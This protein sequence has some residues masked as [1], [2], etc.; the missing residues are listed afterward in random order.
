MATTSPKCARFAV[1]RSY[2]LSAA[3]PQTATSRS[4]SS[5][6]IGRRTGSRRKSSSRL[7]RGR[8]PCPPLRHEGGKRR[9]FVTL[10]Y[11]GV[12]LISS[13]C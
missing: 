8:G 11:L 12:C 7:S 9:N 10:G 5:I 13:V 3:N 6:L 1:R 2:A 4:R